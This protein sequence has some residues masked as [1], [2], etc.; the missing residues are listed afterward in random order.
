MQHRPEAD[1]AQ[2][3]AADAD[4][5]MGCGCDTDGRYEEFAG[6]L[7]CAILVGNSREGG[8][9]TWTIADRQ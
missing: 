4:F 3:L 5:G 1:D 7:C 6:V 9:E 2:V 8:K